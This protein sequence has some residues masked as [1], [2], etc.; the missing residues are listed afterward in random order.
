MASGVKEKEF[1][2]FVRTIRRWLRREA[3]GL[4]GDWHESDDL[5]QM[6]LWKVYQRWDRLDRHTEL[7]AYARRVMLR[8]FLTERRRRHW[9]HEVATH[10]VPD[11]V[12]GPTAHGAIEDRAMLLPALWRLGPRQRAVVTLRLLYDFSVE[13]TAWALGC[14]PGTVTSQ[15]V[16]ALETLRR[17]LQS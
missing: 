5:V 9:R 16:R 12:L 3:Y 6:A 13:Q 8:C 15:L 14:V 11:V 10:A 7:G 17:D 4:C 2:V 1:E